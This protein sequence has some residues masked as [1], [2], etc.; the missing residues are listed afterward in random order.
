MTNTLLESSCGL[1][2]VSITKVCGWMVQIEPFRP[3]YPVTSGGVPS[4]LN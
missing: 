2:L 1:H 4:T 3:F